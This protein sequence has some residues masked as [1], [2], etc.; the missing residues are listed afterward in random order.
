MSHVK[1]EDPEHDRAPFHFKSLGI[2]R[3]NSK[4]RR[5]FDASHLLISLSSLNK[6]RCHRTDPRLWANEMHGHRHCC[7]RHSADLM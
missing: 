6:M 5:D 4:W 7:V 2:E 1:L 3:S